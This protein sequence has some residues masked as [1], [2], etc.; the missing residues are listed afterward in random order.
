MNRITPSP[1][2]PPSIKQNKIKKI[3]DQTATL[4]ASFSQTRIQ[5]IYKKKNKMKYNK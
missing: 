5:F 3:S 1:I 4:S 2:S